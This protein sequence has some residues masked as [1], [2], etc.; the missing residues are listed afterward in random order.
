MTASLLFC[1]EQQ[2]R[3]F[4]ESSDRLHLSAGLGLRIALNN[5]FIVSV[6]YGKAFNP[7]DGTSGLYIGIGNIF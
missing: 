3:Y 2:A 4:S 1:L 5:N 6:D 7:Q